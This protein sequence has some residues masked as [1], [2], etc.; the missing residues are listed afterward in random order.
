M[1]LAG[2][3]FIGI[4]TLGL[5][6]CFKRYT[7][8]K[9]DEQNKIEN[10]I[11]LHFEPPA[12]FDISTSINSIP[13]RVSVSVH[14]CSNQIID[15]EIIANENYFKLNGVSESSEFIFDRTQNYIGP[16]S[17][18]QINMPLR[19]FDPK[20]KNLTLDIKVS[21]KYRARINKEEEFAKE[22]FFK[23]VYENKNN[24]FELKKLS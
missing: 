4:G 20:E 18:S 12:K 3:F 17:L 15:Y 14:N 16:Y 1:S 5:I 6:G 2:A 24:I 23:V 13:I 22:Q 9:F 7:D 10:K 11:L 8:K 21:I 19:S